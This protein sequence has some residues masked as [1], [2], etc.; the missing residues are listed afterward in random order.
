MNDIESEAEK[1]LKRLEEIFAE[2]KVINKEGD[3]FYN[4]AK[5]YFDDGK[6]FFNKEQFVQAFEAFIT[7]WAY[8]DIGLK[9]GLFETNLKKYFTVDK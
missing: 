9:L 4:F 7:A 3:E 5:N 2:L 8:L 6:H 1:E